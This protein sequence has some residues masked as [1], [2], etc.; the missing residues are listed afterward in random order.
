MVLLLVAQKAAKK[1][2]EPTEEHEELVEE[3]EELVV[4]VVPNCHLLPQ[5]CVM[6][7]GSL[8]K[9]KPPS[10]ALGCVIGFV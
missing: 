4:L 10:Y 3:A 9:E 2:V 5:G 7:P 6:A 1:H 8:L